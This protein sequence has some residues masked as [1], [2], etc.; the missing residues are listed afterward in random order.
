MRER[1]GGGVKESEDGWQECVSGDVKDRQSGDGA[2]RRK[3]WKRGF[4]DKI[5]K[6]EAPPLRDVAASRNLLNY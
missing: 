1:E 5:T 6:L 2:A 3:E 4:V